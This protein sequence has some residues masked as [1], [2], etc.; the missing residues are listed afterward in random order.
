[1]TLKA[2]RIIEAGGLPDLH[3]QIVDLPP[4][5]VPILFFCSSATF[6]SVRLR[7]HSHPAEFAHDAHYHADRELTGS[8]LWDN[9]IV[10]K[11]SKTT[12]HVKAELLWH[13]NLMADLK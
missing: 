5:S 9:R 4:F 6:S 8:V 12:G 10:E 13:E 3:S 2:G 11:W 7:L 1:M